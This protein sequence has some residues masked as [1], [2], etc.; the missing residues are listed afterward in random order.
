MPH[1]KPRKSLSPLREIDNIGENRMDILTSLHFEE[2]VDSENP[3]CPSRREQ[4]LYEAEVWSLELKA[5]KLALPMTQERA[6]RSSNSS[7][8][9]GEVSRGET[10]FLLTAR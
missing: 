8:G 1:M 3:R 7:Q 10:D 9:R 5:S 2:S 4:L 6:K